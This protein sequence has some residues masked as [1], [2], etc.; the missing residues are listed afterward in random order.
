[1]KKIFIPGLVLAAIVL[2]GCGLQ[3]T[4]KPAEQTPTNQTNQTTLANPASVNCEQKGG[5]LE[6]ITDL[7][8]SQSGICKF[9]DGTQCEEWA[10]F[11]NECLP[12]LITASSTTATSTTAD[13]L[14]YVNQA[15]GLEFKYPKDWPKPEVSAGVYAG[16]YLPE[17]SDWHIDLGPIFKD[18]C[19]GEDCY[20]LY[21]DKFPA[22]NYANTLKALKSDELIF[23]ITEE[24]IN[25]N[26]VIIFSETG[27]G[28]NIS[29]LIFGANKMIKLQDR[30][31]PSQAGK[32]KQILSTVKLK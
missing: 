28:E 10:F 8:G 15:Y 6:I 7:D 24:T 1:M 14:S 22:R 29:A 3:T 11:R 9:P 23:G 17:R 2:A 4:T 30:S 12:G 20:G 19:E 27:I 21:F 31:F 16:G 13:W 32:F 26:D 18:V 5:T 25:G